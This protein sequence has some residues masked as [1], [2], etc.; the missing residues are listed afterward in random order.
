MK[1]SVLA[2]AAAVEAATGIIVLAYPA[3]VVRL[4][5][6]AEIA[7]ACVSI[8]RLAGVALIGL[9][10]ACWPGADT[11]RAPYGMITYNLLVLLLLIYVGVRG[12]QIGVLL[13]PA[14]VAHGI[15]SALLT[16]AWVKQRNSL[17][18]N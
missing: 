14:V 11:R 2:L 17:A 15:L 13:W 18:K 5:F 1:K 4:L 3:L 12:Q 6:G 16:R 9:A 10:V 7:G 8:S